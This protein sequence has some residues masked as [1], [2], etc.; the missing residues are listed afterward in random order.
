MLCS[1]LLYCCLSVR[2]FRP[3]AKCNGVGRPSRYTVSG[4]PGSSYPVSGGPGSRY[5]VSGGRGI[6]IRTSLGTICT[7]RATSGHTSGLR[8]SFRVAL[9]FLTV[10]PN[11]LLFWGLYY[12]LLLQYVYTTGPHTTFLVI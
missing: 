3:I 6:I 1:A 4:G 11:T 9:S 2:S 7:S 10:F 8:K 5:P 12:I